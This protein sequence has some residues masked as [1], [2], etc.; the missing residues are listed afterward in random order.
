MHLQIYSRNIFSWSLKTRISTRN[1]L[2]R[3]FR[4][5][6]DVFMICLKIY[7]KFWK[8]TQI[9]TSTV[10]MVCTLMGDEWKRNHFPAFMAAVVRSFGRSVFTNNRG[11]AAVSRMD[12]KTKRTHEHVHVASLSSRST[13]GELSMNEWMNK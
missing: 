13:G 9:L 4:F 7:Q 8:V 10:Q 12:G 6:A 11:I 2:S 3:I 5:S 1:S